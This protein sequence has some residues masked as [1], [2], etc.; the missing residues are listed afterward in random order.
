MRTGH[1]TLVDIEQHVGLEH[2]RPY[3]RMASD[4]VHANAH[5][6]YFR[7]GLG[8]ETNALLLVGP[9]SMGLVDAGHS[10]AISLRQITVALLAT[11]PTLDG[12]VASNILSML[13]DEIGQA[14]LEVHHELEGSNKTL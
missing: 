6:A 11:R 1:S 13:Q 10:S 3:Y 7:L 14:F 5:G 2:W 4:N 9:S 8:P 12:I